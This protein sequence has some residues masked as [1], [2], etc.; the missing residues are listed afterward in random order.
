MIRFCCLEN[1]HEIMKL[2]KLNV[3]IRCNVRM[4]VA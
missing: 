2:D 1:F 4:N 3:I